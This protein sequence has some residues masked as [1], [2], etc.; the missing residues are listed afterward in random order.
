VRAPTLEAMAKRP[1]RPRKRKAARD[2]GV[3]ELEID[4]VAMRKNSEGIGRCGTAVSTCPHDLV[5]LA[6]TLAG[7]PSDP[8]TL[9]AANMNS[10]CLPA[11]AEWPRRCSQIR[12]PRLSRVRC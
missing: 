9:R 4:G 5:S 11:S 1:P 12:I 6:I 7:A 2:A 3:I 8:V 10:A